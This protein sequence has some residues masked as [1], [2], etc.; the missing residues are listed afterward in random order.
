[1][2]GEQ[3]INA[4]LDYISYTRFVNVHYLKESIFFLYIYIYSPLIILNYVLEEKYK[5]YK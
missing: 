3:S 5:Y 1:M 2:F 4:R